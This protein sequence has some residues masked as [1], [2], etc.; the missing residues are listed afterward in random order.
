MIYIDKYAYI[1]ALSE[2]RPERK[3]ILGLLSLF[4]C[5]LSSRLLA[6]ATIFLFMVYLTVGKAKIPGKYY[7][8]LMSLPFTFL[9][10]SV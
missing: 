6:F 2:V 3:L 8:K 7:L 10:F 1:S 5:I 4:L 9:F